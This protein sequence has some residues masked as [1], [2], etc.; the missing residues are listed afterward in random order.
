[1]AT[2]SP[3]YASPGL[4]WGLALE[5]H[6]G[7]WVEFTEQTG[8][9]LGIP[10]KVGG[11]KTF[12]VATIHFEGDRKPVV[13]WKAIP[14]NPKVPNGADDLSDAWNILC[15]KT[16]GRALKRAGYPDDLTD[17]KALVVWRQR[18]AEIGAIRG[19]TA[20]LALAP[21]NPERA[22]EAAGKSNPE[23]T[24][25]D[26]GEAPD[27]ETVDAEV[28][29][30]EPDRSDPS[31]LPPS[32]ATKAELRKVINGLGGRSGELTRWARENGLR[33]TKPA[34][35][36]EARQ[37]IAQA[38][39]I[40]AGD[41]G[42]DGGPGPVV[43]GDAP[44]ASTPPQTPADAPSE[45]PAEQ[46]IELVAGLDEDEAKNYAAF[47]KSLK[48]DPKSDPRSWDESVLVEVLGWLEVDE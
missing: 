1:M 40:A 16:L 47:L 20:Q 19:G 4:R 27:T 15:T 46:I 24:G 8:E 21:A 31:L 25:G 34:T 23:A 11:D 38:E 26:D 43:D 44:A 41:A 14:A 32:D 18:D 33:V 7:A 30:N 22:L 10:K 3:T 13:G 45:G 37:L 5:D 39:V 12:C 36:A 2:I 35:E 42:D 28:V 17:L 48:L 29:E 6:P 9:E